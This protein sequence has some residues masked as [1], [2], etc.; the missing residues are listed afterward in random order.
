M[1][2]SETRLGSS[3]TVVASECDSSECDSESEDCDPFECES[4]A[5]VR[6]LLAAMAERWR[7]DPETGWPSESTL[8]EPE[9][10][11]EDVLLAAMAQEP[12]PPL[13]NQRWWEE[14]VPP[15]PTPSW[16]HQL[17]LAQ[18][19]RHDPETGWWSESTLDE[20]AESNEDVSETRA[21]SSDTTS[22]GHCDSE[23]EDW[24]SLDCDSSASYSDRQ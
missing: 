3:D 10:S 9:E 20:P 22:N 13:E 24:D 21:G 17:W 16:E 1:S 2:G 8:D 19:W 12:T 15:L 4:S 18:R 14:P 6:G 5:S 11:N 23:D 7:N